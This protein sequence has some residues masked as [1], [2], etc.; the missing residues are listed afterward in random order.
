MRVETRERAEELGGVARADRSSAFHPIE[1]M[2][3]VGMRERVRLFVLLA[4][5]RQHLV[6]RARGVLLLAVA[7]Q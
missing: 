1:T 4:V 6:C 2:R 3:L 7:A 5:P